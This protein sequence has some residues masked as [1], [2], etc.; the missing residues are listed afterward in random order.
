MPN[1]QQDRS[2]TPTLALV[3]VSSQVQR[4]RQ[5]IE[6]IA[7]YFRCALLLGEPGTGKEATARYLHSL[8]PAAGGPFI[9]C[10]AA[11]LAEDPAPVDAAHRGT[12]FVDDVGSLPLNLQDD[13]VRRIAHLDRRVRARVAET[14][15][16]TASHTNLRSL[17]AAG[18]FR[19]DLYGRLAGVELRIT[20]LRERL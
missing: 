6:R 14:R 9:V 8:S 19:Q 1:I 12:L 10:T 2:Q 17:A 5:H 4:L 16:I 13:L 20:P 7:P 18:H 3:G 15:L 11:A